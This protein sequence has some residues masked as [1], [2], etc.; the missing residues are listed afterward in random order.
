M[1]A[2]AAP[3]AVKP[4][5]LRGGRSL[6]FPPPSRGNTRNYSILSS[7]WRRVIMGMLSILITV[8]GMN[9]LGVPGM[10]DCPE[11]ASHT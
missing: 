10:C 7:D 2:T 5:G 1:A 11:S 6:E 4:L 9:G 8:L 3:V